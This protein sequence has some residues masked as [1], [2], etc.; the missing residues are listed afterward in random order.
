[1]ARIS[2]KVGLALKLIVSGRT[3]TDAAREV[4]LS[5]PHLN[6]ALKKTSVQHEMNTLQATLDK[7]Y[8]SLFGKVVNVLR[9]GL[10]SPDPTIQQ[11]AVRLWFQGSGKQKASVSVTLSAEDVIQKMISGSPMPKIIE[12]NPDE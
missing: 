3:Q 9:E 1:M 6:R 12:H 5:L 2:T 4:G 7:E 8:A 10:N 11:N